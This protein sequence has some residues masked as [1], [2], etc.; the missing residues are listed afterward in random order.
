MAALKVVIKCM[1]ILQPQALN[2]FFAE[3]RKS[4]A[5]LTFAE[6]LDQLFSA[7]NSALPPANRT[8]EAQYGARARHYPS[9]LELAQF[10]RTARAPIEPAR[11]SGELLNVWSVAR[12]RTDELRN[13]AILNW[14]LD[15]NESH[16]RGARFFG[17]AC[18]EVLQ[19]DCRVV[20]HMR[21][22]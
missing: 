18:A 19:T 10:F 2:A 5:S 12:V 9:E 3:W 16:G 20:S 13:A 6:E 22:S 17:Q 15:I 14:L 7:L 8:E 1:V 4:R 21:A 11:S